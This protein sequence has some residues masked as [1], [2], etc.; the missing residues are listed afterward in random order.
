MF[1]LLQH[2]KK[3][4]IANVAHLLQHSATAPMQVHVITCGGMVVD[5]QLRGRPDGDTSHYY[6]AIGT[7]SDEL[8]LHR[9]DIFPYG[10]RSPSDVLCAK[11][12][13]TTRG[14]VAGVAAD[15]RILVDGADGLRR[16]VA[17]PELQLLPSLSGPQGSPPHRIGARVQCRRPG[18]AA[19]CSGTV[20][21][22]KHDLT[23]AVRFDDDGATVRRLLHSDMRTVDRGGAEGP[24][25]RDRVIVSLDG[26]HPAHVIEC[27]GARKFRV[28]LDG[29]TS[30]AVTVDQSRFV[31]VAAAVPALASSSLEVRDLFNRL[32]TVS[33]HVV[34]RD[35]REALLSQEAYG[36]RVTA[37]H[38]HDA[39]VEMSIWAQRPVKYLL[40]RAKLEDADMLLT[41]AEFEYVVLRVCNAV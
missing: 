34:W 3:P 18:V 32:R 27:L 29:H 33:G 20:V 37:R 30:H 7:T 2:K 40:T 36:S 17:L 15:T 4:S 22:A 11:G 1:A 26:H 12:C 28:M 13:H 8:L 23:Y 19:L 25:I 38:V 10:F 41:F 5:A 21:S 35:A 9:H 16:A 24:G 6:V 14:I 31:D 39:L